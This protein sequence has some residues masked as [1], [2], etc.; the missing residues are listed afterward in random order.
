MSGEIQ[1]KEELAVFQEENELKLHAEVIE[2]GGLTD[3]ERP[4]MQNGQYTHKLLLK[5]DD[6]IKSPL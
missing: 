5:I 4:E 3:S 2:M 6:V 1:G